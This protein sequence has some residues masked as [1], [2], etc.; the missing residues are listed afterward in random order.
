[1]SKNEITVNEFLSRIERKI[2]SLELNQLNQKEVLTFN[3]AARYAGLSRS[4]LYKLTSA[5]KICH[6]KPNGKMIYFNRRELEKWLLRNQ[7]EREEIEVEASTYVTLNKGGG[8][9]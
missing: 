7:A 9:S 5:G 2:D 4:Y 3:E 6:Y 8:Q 1:M